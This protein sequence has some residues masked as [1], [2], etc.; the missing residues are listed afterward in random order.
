MT[1]PKLHLRDLFWLVLVIALSLG[2][3]LDR[4]AI[5]ARMSD[6]FERES[7]ALRFFTSAVSVYLA[8]H[9]KPFGSASGQPLTSISSTS[10]I[11]VAL[12]GMT[13]PAPR[14]P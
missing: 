10:K 6:E 12:G 2:W 11:S 4:K 1:L 5:I 7:A 13:P 14:S 3:W 8:E 9:G